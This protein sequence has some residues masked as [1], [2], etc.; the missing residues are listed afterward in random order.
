MA[1]TTSTVTAVVSPVVS[2]VVNAT[3]PVTTA[4]TP[5]LGTATNATSPVTA[6]VTPTENSVLASGEAPGEGDDAA[7]G[8]AD[9]GV[10]VN[11]TV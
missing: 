8:E 2:S 9:D 10:G 11:V 1:N 5:V 3:S 4:A 7:E 6:A